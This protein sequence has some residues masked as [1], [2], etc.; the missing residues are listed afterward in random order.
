VLVLTKKYSR[1]YVIPKIIQDPTSVVPIKI[2]D[3]TS[4]V[5]IQIR[6]LASVVILNSEPNLDA[7]HN[8]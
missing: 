8:T 5:S 1:T 7:T 6:D 4:V 3:R 2:R